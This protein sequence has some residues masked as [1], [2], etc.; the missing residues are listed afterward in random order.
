MLEAL[1]RT[2]D[3]LKAG[4]CSSGNCCGCITTAIA[5]ASKL[6]E[7]NAMSLIMAVT[8]AK[9]YEEAEKELKRL[10]GRTSTEAVA[11]LDNIIGWFQLAM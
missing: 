8:R 11:N 7:T 2:R 6:T 9:T 3:I 1:K 5:K 10:S 4:C